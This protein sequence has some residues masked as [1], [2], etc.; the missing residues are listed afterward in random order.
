VSDEL[1]GLPTERVLR[2]LID[3]VA[4]YAIFVLTPDGHVASWSPGAERIKGYTAA[5]ILGQHFRAFYPPREQQEKKPEQELIAAARAGRFEDEGWRIRK[6][7]TRFWA[8]VII[9]ALRD[10]TGT[11]V[12]FGKITRDLTPR[13]DAEARYRRVVEGV[14]DYAISTLDVNGMVTS[15]NEGASR[16]EQ[17]SE[18]E[19]LGQPFSCFYLPEDVANRRPQRSLAAAVEHGQYQ[20][21][22]W[23]LR[24]DG[25]RFWSSIAI[26]PIFDDDGQLIGF[27]EIVRDMTDRNQLIEQIQQY[28]RDLEQRIA[29][30][31][32]TMTDLESFNYSVSHDL[33]APLRAIEGFAAALKEDL[34]VPAAAEVREDLFQIT[35]AVRRMNVLIDDLL[36]YSRVSRGEMEV[37][38]VDVADVMGAVLE[39]DPGA[40]I[41]AAI[42]PGVRVRAHRSALRQA[43]LNLVDNA[44]KFHKPG[45]PPAVDIIAS[46][47]HDNTVRIAVTDEGIGI[48]PEHHQRIF[49]I[50]QRLHPGGAYPGTGVG[51]AL[52]K[53][54]AERFGGAVG[55]ES[56]AGK[57]STFWIDVPAA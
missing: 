8:N 24:R 28:A 32:R 14:R 36:A 25:T 35:S 20:D 12:G 34:P 45:R 5:D 9:Q 53:R 30:R 4:D 13:R 38:E 11:L 31:D 46:R 2:L 47:H 50:F 42:E 39:L 3:S 26:T 56:E 57:G 55:V 41:R 21:E 43:V 7:G 18:S 6:N 48:A 40:S 22:A 16:L 1:K 10:E 51:L 29:E 54:I 23:R 49:Q 44:L 52:V 33:R 37:A 15:W 17:Y 27:S 19:I